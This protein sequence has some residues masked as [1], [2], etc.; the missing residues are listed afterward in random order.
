MAS[1]VEGALAMGTLLWG[2]TQI[3]RLSTTKTMMGMMKLA[4]S[5]QAE[6]EVLAAVEMKCRG[7]KRPR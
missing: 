5:Q 3:E 7:A 4:A 1:R 2:P 6:A